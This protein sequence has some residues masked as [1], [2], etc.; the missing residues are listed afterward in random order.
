ME[1]LLVLGAFALAGLGAL[2]FVGLRRH[3]RAGTVR[4]VLAPRI[5][6]MRATDSDEGAAGAAG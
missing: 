2:G 4:A 6:S 1:L 3:Q 5:D